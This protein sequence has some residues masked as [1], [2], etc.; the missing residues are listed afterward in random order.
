[1]SSVYMCICTTFCTGLKTGYNTDG[2]FT[3]CICSTTNYIHKTAK[4][5]KELHFTHIFA[6][7]H[8]D[9]A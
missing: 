8:S 6:N 9:K 4:D 5:K 2:L 3:L 7:D 1:M